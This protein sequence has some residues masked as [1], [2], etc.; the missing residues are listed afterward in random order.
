MES[1]LNVIHASSFSTSNY[2]APTMYQH[3]ATNQDWV[4]NIIAPAL[5]EHQV[6]WERQRNKKMNAPVE[7][8]IDVLGKQGR[9]LSRHAGQRDFPEEGQCE[10]GLVRWTGVH[11]L[12]ILLI[13]RKLSFI[14]IQIHKQY[15]FQ[16]GVLVSHPHV[17]IFIQSLSVASQNQNRYGEMRM[18]W[19]FPIVLFYYKSKAYTL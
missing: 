17:S 13:L 1:G 12:A 18:V 3:S 8:Q 19:N 2:W 9:L 16:A 14:C 5:K 7:G 15:R 4:V 10:L 11:H 6:W